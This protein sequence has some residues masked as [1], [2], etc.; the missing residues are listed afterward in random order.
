[1]SDITIV[2]HSCGNRITVSEF[3]SA[4]SLTC[5]KC[6]TAVPIP[7]A[8]PAGRETERPRLNVK[9]AEDI[10]PPPPAT[11]PRRKPFFG[12]RS[13][14]ERTATSLPETFGTVQASMPAIRR[15]VRQRRYSAFT[16][17]V[18]PW[19]TFILA[20]A[21]LSYLRYWPGALPA[22]RLTLLVH[23]GVCALLLLHVTIIVFAFGEDPFQGVLCALIPG[24]TLYY[25]IA[26][27][28]QY[29]IR[30]IVL[31]LMI[32]F[33][34]DTALAIR[35]GWREF[36]HAANSWLRDTDYFRHEIPTK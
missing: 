32:A 17:K 22:E 12:A 29:L 36:Y 11:P 3:V 30:A 18:G 35:T 28:D 20:A 27:S 2:C 31:A 13:K 15:R 5:M 24:Y 33:G 23:G 10:P 19:I 8:K 4:V 6:K 7:A 1:M 16:H 25:L 9:A 14:P 34:F 26:Q 21:V